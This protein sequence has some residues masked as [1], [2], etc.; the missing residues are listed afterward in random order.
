MRRARAAGGWAQTTRTV[1]RRLGLAMVVGLVASSAAPDVAGAEQHGDWQPAVPVA[2]VNGPATEGCPIESP[3]GLRL[4]LMSTRGPGGDQDIW[5]AD[6]ADAGSDFGE[7]Q[8]LPWPI[9]SDANDF[10][11]TPLRGNW[12]LFVSNRGGTD[13]YGTQACG[14]GDIYLT[15]RSPATGTWAA[16]RNLGCTSDGGPNGPGTEFG[17]TVVETG[18]GRLLLFSSGGDLGT[19]TQDIY[20]SLEQAEWTFGLPEAVASLNSDRDDIMPNISKDG[21]EIVFASNRPGGEGAFDI[22]TSTRESILEPWSTP[23][24]LGTAVNGPGPETRPSLSWDGS[25]LYFGRAGEIHVSGR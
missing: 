14:G 19:N 25:R 23:T 21:R 6:R 3:D 2:T 5:V 16:P 4:Y 13:A 20:A 1:G 9:N 10:C 22:W 7:P 8:Q 15:R 17:P 11:P 24:N 18:A 12:L